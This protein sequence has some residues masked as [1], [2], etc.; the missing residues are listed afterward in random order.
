MRTNPEFEFAEYEWQTIVDAL[1][2]Y[3]DWRFR[4]VDIPVPSQNLLCDDHIS[5]L[6]NRIVSEACAW[7]FA[8]AEGRKRRKPSGATG[9]C[10]RGDGARNETALVEP[11]SE[12]DHRQPVDRFCKRC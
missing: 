7:R 3:R 8:Q 6:A 9:D 2:F 10:P 5:A 4:G 11:L 1:R 12:L